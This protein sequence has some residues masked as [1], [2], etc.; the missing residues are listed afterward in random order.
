M[1]LIN[2]WRYP[3]SG[4][5]AAAYLG[6]GLVALP[7]KYGNRVTVWD[8]GDLAERGPGPRLRRREPRGLG[9]R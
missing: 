3:G 2:Y 4:A 6:D 5:H 9:L 1:R 7:A 8:I